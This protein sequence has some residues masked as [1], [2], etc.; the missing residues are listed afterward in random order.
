MGMEKAIIAKKTI[1]KGILS[2]EF[3]YIVMPS[4]QMQQASI[5]FL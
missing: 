5:H 2:I 1:A 4:T 3:G